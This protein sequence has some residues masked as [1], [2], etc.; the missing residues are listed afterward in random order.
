MQ[1]ERQKTHKS[2]ISNL[3][4]GRPMA[5]AD[6]SGKILATFK[7]ASYKLEN[8]TVKLE[9]VV[10][11]S[12]HLEIGMA[13]VSLA[14]NV[15]IRVHCPMEFHTVTGCGYSPKMVYRLPRSYVIKPHTA[16]EVLSLYDRA[17]VH[18]FEEVKRV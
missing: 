4:L 5:V 1:K 6:G 13:E 11:S 8:G 10:N 16:K 18:T 9:L 14:P 2:W 15:S 7:L 17:R 3:G 12:T